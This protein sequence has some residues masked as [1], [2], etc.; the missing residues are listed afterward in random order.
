MSYEAMAEKIISIELIPSFLST[1]FSADMVKIK[2]TERGFVVEPVDKK[3]MDNNFSCPF[4][5]TAMG[6]TLTVDEFMKMKRDELEL[7][8]QNDKRLFP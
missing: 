6:G 3:P 5:G 8:N 4:L 2:Q 7:E 1:H